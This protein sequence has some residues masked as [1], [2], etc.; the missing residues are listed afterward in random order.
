MAHRGHVRTTPGGTLEGSNKYGHE[1]FGHFSG[2][3]MKSPR[4]VQDVDSI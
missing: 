3:D 4:V 2:V 1:G